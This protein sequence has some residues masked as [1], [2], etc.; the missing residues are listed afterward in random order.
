[1]QAAAPVTDG[2]SD[3]VLTP[4]FAVYVLGRMGF[5]PRKGS[6]FSVEAFNALGGTD[7]ARLTAFVTQQLAPTRD[8]GGNVTDP[9]VT[10]RLANIDYVTL[11]K[12]F[13]QLWLDHEVNGSISG[14]TYTR[15][16]PARE[17]E[18]AV[19]VR[20]FYSRWGCTSRSPISGTTTSIRTALIATQ[21]RPGPVLIVM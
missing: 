14:Q 2:L 20:G 9:D 13:N 17:I 8:A 21:R 6:A 11:N 15:D 1:M 12:T 18:R 3:R 5:G 4:P 19:F 7:D 10:S 16:W